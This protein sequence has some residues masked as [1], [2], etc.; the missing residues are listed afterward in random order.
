MSPAKPTNKHEHEIRDTCLFFLRV[1]MT[2]IFLSLGRAREEIWQIRREYRWGRGWVWYWERQE[3]VTFEEGKG[4]V[5][6]RDD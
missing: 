3:F 1:F 6:W 2:L 5:W 4:W